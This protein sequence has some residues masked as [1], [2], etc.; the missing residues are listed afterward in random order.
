[1]P[2]TFYNTL[3]RRKAE[4]SPVN[5]GKVH[6]YTCGPTIYGY[7]H[8]GNFRAYIF[9]D[10]LRR[11]LEYKGF[12]VLHVMNITDVDDKTIRDSQKAG[13]PLKD[14]TRKYEEAFFRDRDI[15]NIKPAHVYPRATEHIPEMLALVKR[16]QDKGFT[17]ESEGSIYFR[18]A[19]FP[20]YGQLS[21]MVVEGLKAGAR[22]EHDEYEKEEARD[23]ALWKAWREEDGDVWWDSPFGKGRPGWHLECSAMSM[24]Y[25]GETFDIH[26]GGVDNIFPHHENEIAQSEAAAGKKFVNYWLHCGY[27]LVEG[28]KMSKSKGNYF[29]I[30]QLTEGYQLPNGEIVNRVSPQ[31]IRYALLSVHYRQQLNFTLRSLTN[32]ELALERLQIFIQ[33][34]QSIK[35]DKSKLKIDDLIVNSKKKFEEAMDDDLNISG[36]LGHIFSFVREINIIIDN[37]ELSHSDAKSILTF[38]EEIDM[39]LSVMNFENPEIDEQIEELIRHREKARSNR[40]W[41]S[42]DK[43]REKLA[44]MSIV[45]EDTPEGTRWKKVK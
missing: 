20:N 1:M 42:A 27:L 21:G 8:I 33:R 40:D 43:I 22:V 2:L 41:S 38:L 3:T 18:I 28:E 15:L 17:Y 14:F 4:F 34:L 6:I 36:A 29:T 37:D 35:S 7:A 19:A 45:L 32:A 16:L 12:E 23:F 26:C 11:Y 10:L 30:K 5:P 13:L 44:E 24:K 25:L 9:E 31:T 39:V